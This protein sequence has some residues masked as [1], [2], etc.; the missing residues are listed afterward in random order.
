M[1]AAIVAVDDPDQRGSTPEAAVSCPDGEVVETPPLD[2]VR[3]PAF[4]NPR[5]AAEGWAGPGAGEVTVSADSRIAYLLRD[6][7][8]ARA[9]MHLDSTRVDLD[10]NEPTSW[11]VN[12]SQVCSDET[13]SANWEGP[14]VAGCA[15]GLARGHVTYPPSGD[16]RLLS[17]EELRDF[18]DPRRDETELELTPGAKSGDVTVTVA[19]SDGAHTWLRVLRVDDTWRVHEVAAC[20]RQLPGLPASGTAELVHL[21]VGHCWVD[22]L[23]HGGREWAVESDK[24]FGWGGQMPERWTAYGTVAREGDTLRYVDAGG[25]ELELLGADDART[26]LPGGGMCS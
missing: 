24:Q 23:T 19:D 20:S 6:D 14:E 13:S 12:G 1:A 8:S 9:L 25:A 21:N 15:D 17:A 22:P 3:V 16:R 4:E 26:A 10:D 7:G 5:E 11:W 18:S 2:D